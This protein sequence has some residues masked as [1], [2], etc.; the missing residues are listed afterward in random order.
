MLRGIAT[1][2]LALAVANAN[3][4]CDRIKAR[5]GPVVLDC[6]NECPVGG[7]Y[8]GNNLLAAA[9]VGGIGMRIGF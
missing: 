8:D 2:V 4:R 3:Q 5:L 1:F 7:N 9:E 6:A